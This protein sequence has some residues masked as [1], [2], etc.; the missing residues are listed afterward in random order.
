[1]TE[2]EKRL[3]GIEESLKTLNDRLAWMVQVMPVKKVLKIADIAH[4][5]G[6]APQVIRLRPWLLPNLGEPDFEDLPRRWTLESVLRWQAQYGSCPERARKDWEDKQR[7]L[8]EGE[9]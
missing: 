3:E 8:L 4:M 5:Q 2:T 9:N 6:I 7:R 1:M